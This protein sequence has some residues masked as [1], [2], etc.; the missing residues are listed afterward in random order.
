MPRISADILGPL[1]HGYKNRANCH[2]Y[3]FGYHMRIFSQPVHRS[4]LT[5][6]FGQA[7][8]PTVQL[9]PF[10][11]TLAFCNQPVSSGRPVG[12]VRPVFAN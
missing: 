12:P 1:C 11:T 6:R 7:K 10:H 2:G 8:S 5:H 9:R 3:S 4:L